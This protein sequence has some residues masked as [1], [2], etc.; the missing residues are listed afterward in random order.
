M[1]TTYS[2]TWFRPVGDPILDLRGPQH[3]TQ[4]AQREQ[5]DFLA[6]LNQQHLDARP[7]GRELAARINSYELAY[8]MQSATPEAVDLSQESQPTLD[9]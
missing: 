7:G 5:L 3:M 4:K 8:R 2:G 6:E 9:M 1:P